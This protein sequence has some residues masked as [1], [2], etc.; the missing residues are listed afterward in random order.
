MGAAFS[1]QK[2]DRPLTT[3]NPTMYVKAIPLREL[4][5]VNKIVAEI[6]EGNI[7][8]IRITPIAR[9]SIKET[10]EAV[11]KLR[12]IISQQGG[13]IARLGTERIVITP[14]DVKIWR[15]E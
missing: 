11:N 7:L 6:S 4:S 12:Q 5:D 9:H 1:L 8:I 15:G 2:E 13:D 10:K 14:P 3:N